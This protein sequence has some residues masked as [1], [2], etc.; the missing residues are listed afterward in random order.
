MIFRS[1]RLEG[2][3]CPAHHLFV[4]SI[5]HH[6]GRSQDELA[7]TLC[8]N[9][10]TVTRTLGVLEERGYVRRELNPQDKRQTLVYPTERMQA[11]L[12]K[13]KS[14][15]AEWNEL[16]TEGISE[17]ETEIFNSVLQRMED[18]ARRAIGSEGSEK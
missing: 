18:N 1:D 15:A 9:K 4:F 3:L 2:D 16:L 8:L 11:L 13:I 10:S 7:R 5:C 6:P 14:I 12:P 17:E